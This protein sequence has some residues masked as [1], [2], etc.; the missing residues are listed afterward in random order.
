MWS[1]GGHGKHET[2]P[3]SLMGHKL[4]INFICINAKKLI[5]VIKKDL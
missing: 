5:Y 1:L 2:A 3:C 4:N